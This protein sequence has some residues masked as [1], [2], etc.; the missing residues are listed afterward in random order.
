VVWRNINGESFVPQDM[1][2]PF[3]NGIPVD[4]DGDGRL[5][6]VASISSNHFVLFNRTEGGGYAV[7]V[8]VD[9]PL[10]SLVRGYYADGSILVQQW[11]SADTSRFSQGLQ[12]LRFGVGEVPLVSVGVQRPGEGTEYVRATLVEGTNRISI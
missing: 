2:N 5:D 8:N 12:P 7:I 3:W 10:G 1:G 9:A 4:V 11:G 6:V